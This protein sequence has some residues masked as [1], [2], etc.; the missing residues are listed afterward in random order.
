MYIPEGLLLSLIEHSCDEGEPRCDGSFPNTEEE[1]SYHESSEASACS[2]AHQDAA[3]DKPDHLGFVQN[4][5]KETYT[6][7]AR[8]FP[9]GNRTIT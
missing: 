7:V 1:M 2:V 6:D 8:Y 3:P 9:I 5:V 4:R